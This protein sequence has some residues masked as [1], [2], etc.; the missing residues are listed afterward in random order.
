MLACVR[1]LWPVAF[2]LAT[3]LALAP[4]NGAASAMEYIHIH[5]VNADARRKLPSVAHD[6][7]SHADAQQCSPRSPSASISSLGMR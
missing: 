4:T 7:V 6:N 1:S 2:S 3:W 5:P